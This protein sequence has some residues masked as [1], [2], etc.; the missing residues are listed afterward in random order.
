MERA[1]E[2][3]EARRRAAAATALVEQTEKM[4]GDAQAQ[5]RA[6]PQGGGGARSRSAAPAGGAGG[7]SSAIGSVALSVAH[8]VVSRSAAVHSEASRRQ[9]PVGGAVQRV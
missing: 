2:E 9:R 8:D 6:D 7:A 1:A 4:L 5:A 3:Y